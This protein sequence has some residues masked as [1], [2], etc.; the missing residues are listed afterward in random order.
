MDIKTIIILVIIL[1]LIVYFSGILDCKERF[2]KV[3][4]SKCTGAFLSEKTNDIIINAFKENEA[5]GPNRKFLAKCQGYRGSGVQVNDTLTCFGPSKYTK[6]ADGTCDSHVNFQKYLCSDDM[7][8]PARNTETGKFDNNND[9]QR[10]KC[11]KADGNWVPAGK[12][13]RRCKNYLK[14]YLDTE[15]IN[16]K[17]YSVCRTS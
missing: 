4:A 3:D 15:K 7:I 6:Y 11:Q 16:N 9:S 13:K 10:L 17:I 2:A 12:G 1:A 5:N 8:N 14:K